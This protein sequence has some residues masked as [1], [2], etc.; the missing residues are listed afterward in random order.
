MKTVRSRV[1]L[2]LAYVFVATAMAVGIA[3]V[4][5]LLTSLSDANAS[6]VR[7]MMVGIVPALTVSALAS[8]ASFGGF[9]RRAWTAASLGLVGVGVATAA[10]QSWYAQLDSEPTGSDVT[11]ILFAAAVLIVGAAL[12]T[13]LVPALRRTRLGAGGAVAVGF[14]IGLVAA[15]ALVL[16]LATPFASLLL[17]VAALVA[18]AGIARS[19][20]VRAAGAK[21]RA[22]S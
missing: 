8:V 15:G 12:A 20:G 18:I 5:I 19:L 1:W 13:V 21:R 6:T 16:S 2:A 14:V 22:H 7:T 9:T 10:H 11:A 4:I 3:A 17:A